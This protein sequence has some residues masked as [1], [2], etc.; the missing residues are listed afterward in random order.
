MVDG[1]LW[2]NAPG[3]WVR[4]KDLPSMVERELRAPKSE[5]IRKL[6]HPL[7]LTSIPARVVGWPPRGGLSE[8]GEAVVLSLTR[9]LEDTGEWILLPKG[10]ENVDWSKGTLGDLFP[11]EVSWQH[12]EAYVGSFL[13]QKQG[14][15]PPASP[16]PR[17]DRFARARAARLESTIGTSF[18][19]KWLSTPI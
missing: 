6:R 11:I 16:E 19:S 10:W 17:Q 3:A 4:L 7:E 9:R 12:I 5:A 13:P 15:L 18:G 1:D 2:V 14:D 8:N